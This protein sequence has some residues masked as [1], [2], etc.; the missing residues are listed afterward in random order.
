MMGANYRKPNQEIEINVIPKW[1]SITMTVC[2]W[3]VCIAPFIITSVMW[4]SIS[5]LTTWD[6]WL[7]TCIY[8]LSVANIINM[9]D[10]K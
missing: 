2:K 1:M 8:S 9:T 6:N 3:F 5:E 4:F 7:L 10:K